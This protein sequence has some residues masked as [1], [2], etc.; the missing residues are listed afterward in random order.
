MDCAISPLSSGLLEPEETLREGRVP[1]LSM[2]ASC[3]LAF[4]CLRM[5]G[6]GV[7]VGDSE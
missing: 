1:V 4:L 5:V 3:L 7:G 2:K 6:L